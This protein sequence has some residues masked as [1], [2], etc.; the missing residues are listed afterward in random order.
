LIHAE[1]GATVMV[2]LQDSAVS[3]FHR[4]V[5]QRIAAWLTHRHCDY[6]GES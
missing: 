4:D 3:G 6:E 5:V 2:M 1:Q